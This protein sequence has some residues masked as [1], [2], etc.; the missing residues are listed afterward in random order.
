MRELGL[1]YTTEQEKHLD[2][3]EQYA[4]TPKEVRL[5]E[6][7]PPIDPVR[8]KLLTRGL[9]QTGIRACEAVAIKIDAHLDREA[10]EITIPASAAKTNQKRIVAYQPSLDPLLRQWLDDGYRARYAYAADSPY[11]F[12]TR[13]SPQMSTDAV[14]DVIVDA[15]DAAGIN[16]VLYTD[17]QD[18]ER[19]KITPHALRH[20]FATQ[21][22]KYY[23]ADD[24]DGDVTLYQV[25]KA[26]GHS[27]TEV[28]QRMYVT[29]DK[30]AG[31][32]AMHRYGPE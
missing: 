22:L 11:L 26:L 18:G 6:D 12:V 7:H 21:M 14:T 17:A 30:E 13:R 1:T 10:R 8:D 9:W 2:A 23:D 29:H 28:T 3:D 20:G 5:M 27:S 15:A 24:V 19:W 4:V 16:R 31:T 32:E 25:S